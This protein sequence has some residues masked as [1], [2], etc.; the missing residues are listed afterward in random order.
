MTSVLTPA[1][2]RWDAFAATVSE[3]VSKHGCQHDYRLAEPIMRQMD[4]VDISGSL[5]FFEQYGGYCDCE[6]LFNV[7]RSG[8]GDAN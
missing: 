4:G 1:D 7:E 3:A 8:L 2:P 5:T 6:I